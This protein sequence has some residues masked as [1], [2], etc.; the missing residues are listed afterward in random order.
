MIDYEK[1]TEKLKD[2]IHQIGR[3]ISYGIRTTDFQHGC[4]VGEAIAYGK[5][6]DD[7]QNQFIDETFNIQSAPKTGNI[8]VDKIQKA[9]DS[10]CKHE[11][12][13]NPYD[14]LTTCHICN[15]TM[16]MDEQDKI[17]LVSTSG[18]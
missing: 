11:W 6:L 10:V 13:T 8:P 9:V 17:I 1:L 2:D 3:K 5:M 4:L 18:I 12:H 15:A 16:Q 14:F 7:L